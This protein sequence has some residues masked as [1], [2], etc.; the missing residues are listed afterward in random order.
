M[1]ERTTASRGG[2]EVPDTIPAVREALPE[3]RRDQFDYEINTATVLN[4]HATLRKWMLEATPE[5]DADHITAELTAAEQRAIDQLPKWEFTL[6]LDRTLTE[7]DVEPFA[8]LGED[9]GDYAN[10]SL[11]ITFGGIT[12]SESHCFTPGVSLFDAASRASA[13]IHRHTGARTVRIEVD[14]EHRGDLDGIARV[15]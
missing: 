9:L 15:A 8:Q 6:I 5:A 11:G 2:A 3:D 10:G 13:A 12:P 1:P 4:I 14:E 7:E